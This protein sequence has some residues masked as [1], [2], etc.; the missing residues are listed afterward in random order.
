M[1]FC[2]FSVLLSMFDPL[3][4]LTGNSLIWGGFSIT[5]GLLPRAFEYFIFFCP[6]LRAPLSVFLCVHSSLTFP[7]LQKLN[8]TNRT[9]TS[10]KIL[11]VSLLRMQQAQGTHTGNPA[12]PV[13]EEEK[14]VDADVSPRNWPTAVKHHFTNPCVFFASPSCS[15]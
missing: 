2:R 1:P 6:K 5:H 15:K 14:E 13:A 10:G 7:R 11:H 12:T 9:K 3:L 4:V 8:E